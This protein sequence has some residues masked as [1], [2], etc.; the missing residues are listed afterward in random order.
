MVSLDGGVEE[1]KLAA[2]V[3]EDAGPET[4]RYAGGNVR[5]PIRGGRA[6]ASDHAVAHGQHPPVENPPANVVV[7]V[8]AA[9]GAAVPNGHPSEGDHAG[10]NV[11]HPK[12]RR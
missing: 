2:F 9:E 3:A 7:D 8:G 10:L 12:A 6:V 5:A 11:E 1:C 4:K